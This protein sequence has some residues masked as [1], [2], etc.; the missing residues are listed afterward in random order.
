MDLGPGSR[1]AHAGRTVLP[2]GRPAVLLS[3]LS[4][5][6]YLLA[7]DTADSGCVASHLPI[8]ASHRLSAARARDAALRRLRALNRLVA[9]AAVVLVL[10]FTALAANATPVKHGGGTNGIAS[11]TVATASGDSSAVGPVP[12]GTSTP[13]PA[14]Q[15]VA[16]APTAQAPV[17][18]S[19]GS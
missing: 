7:K 9:V 19:G 2:Q 5:T 6:A 12:A 17:V 1:R 3:V 14:P 4:A 11:A 8:H 10:A 13:A 16:P 18:V 15:V